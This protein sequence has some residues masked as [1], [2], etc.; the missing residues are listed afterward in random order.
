MEERSAGK[1]VLFEFACK[2]G[3]QLM[4]HGEY[5][6]GSRGGMDSVKCR[7]CMAEHELPTRPLRFFYQEGDHWTTVLEG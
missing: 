4:V 1:F 6:V 2:C 3:T 7:K 5:F